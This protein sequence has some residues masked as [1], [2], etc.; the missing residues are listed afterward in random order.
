[1]DGALAALDLV[2]M[3]RLNFRDGALAAAMN[4]FVAWARQGGGQI[5]LPAPQVDGFAVLVFTLGLIR[6]TGNTLQR[7]NVLRE[8]YL[9]ADA[10]TLASMPTTTTAAGG[11]STA[12]S[13]CS[14]TSCTVSCSMRGAMEF[15][16]TG[17]PCSGQAQPTL[18]STVAFD[19]W[20][21]PTAVPDDGPAIDCPGDLS[22]FP[23]NVFY[24]EKGVTAKFCAE[25][26]KNA[27]KPLEWMVNSFGDQAKALRARTPPPNP[28]G[29]K[30]YRIILK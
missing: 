8:T 11:T 30:D 1:M 23:G 21:W 26:E 16:K 28:D 5:Q 18:Y 2:Q 25:V 17:C 3:P 9:N 15:C 12:A 7:I 14:T 13:S 24:K 6:A 4:Q 20:A 22:D 29:W 19:I 27:K 10:P